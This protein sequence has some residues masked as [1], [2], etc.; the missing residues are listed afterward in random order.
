MVTSRLSIALFIVGEKL[1]GFL[2][3]K[4]VGEMY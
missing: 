4:K 2:Q 3:K 1:A